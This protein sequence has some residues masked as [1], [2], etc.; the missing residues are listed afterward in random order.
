MRDQDAKTLNELATV[1]SAQT[2]SQTIKY[3][4]NRTDRS[5]ATTNRERESAHGDVPELRE[6][7]EMLGRP[8]VGGV[9][10]RRRSL[11]GLSQGWGVGRR[12]CLPS[13]D[14]IQIYDV[15]ISPLG[16]IMILNNNIA[17][18]KK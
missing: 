14:C 4:N 7:I 16:I 11:D 6:S 3:A 9:G 10:V 8:I 15:I 18:E 5:A 2:K 1:E 12:R 13:G 17:L